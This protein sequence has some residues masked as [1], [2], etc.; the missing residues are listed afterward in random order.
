MSYRICAFICSTPV[1]YLIDTS[2]AVSLLSVNIWQRVAGHC[3]PIE[4]WTGQ[5]LF[6]VNGSALSIKGV[7]GL[8]LSLEGNIFNVP[9]AVTDDILVVRKGSLPI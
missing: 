9:F 2:A 4:K 7:A 3:R 5:T 6:G 1:E 8:P